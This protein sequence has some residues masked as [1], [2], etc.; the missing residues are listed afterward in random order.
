[1]IQNIFYEIYTFAYRSLP[2]QCLILLAFL[3]LLNLFLDTLKLI[4]DKK[5]IFKSCS[6]ALFGK[7]ICFILIGLTHGLDLS[8]YSLIHILFIQ[9]VVVIAY[10]SQ[11]IRFFA[12]HLESFCGVTVVSYAL[13]RTSQL[14]DFYLDRLVDIL[15]LIKPIKNNWTY[16]PKLVQSIQTSPIYIFEYFK[17]NFSI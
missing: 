16:I 10:F 1:M 12:V 4:K 9:Y 2:Y 3:M 15:L 17:D 8:L 7:L 6:Y 13:F 5:C 14:I 11:E